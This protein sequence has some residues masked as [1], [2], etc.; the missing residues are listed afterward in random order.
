MPIPVPE[1]DPGPGPVVGALVGAGDISTCE[2][3]NDEATA[4]LLDRVDGTIF[5]VGDNVYE[6]GTARQFRDC[7]DPTWG[8]HLARTRPSPGNHDYK[9]AGASGYYAYF[10][11]NAGAAGVGYYSYDVGGWHVLSLNSTVPSSAGTPQYE[12]LRA[13]LDANKTACAVAYWHHP[14]FSSGE[15]GN[16]STMRSVLRLL[17]ER[18]VEVV[19]NG[20]DHDYER[21]GLQ[22]PDGRPDPD[23]GFRQFIVGTGGKGI[24]PFVRIQSNSEVRGETGAFGV[25]KLTLRQAGYDWE[26]I[27]VAGATFRD[28]GSGVCR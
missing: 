13:D 21:F 22:N 9:T 19:V 28:A 20:H 17:Y 5:T 8:R 11:S 24:D 18:G 10:G 15:H 6:S 2:N 7:Y 27:P 16:D 26:F 23:R 3:N 14:V 4:R 12:W 1:P 25:L